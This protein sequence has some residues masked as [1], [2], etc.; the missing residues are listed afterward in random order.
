MEGA[1]TQVCQHVGLCSSRS[2][3][4]VKSE[5]ASASVSRKLLAANATSAQPVEDPGQFCQFCQMAVNYIKVR[6]CPLCSH[7]VC[8]GCCQLAIPRNSPCMQIKHHVS[9]SS[10]ML[11]FSCDV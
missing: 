2:A 6:S 7:S 9:S 11:H 4:A 1:G 3:K 8:S 5:A 10:L